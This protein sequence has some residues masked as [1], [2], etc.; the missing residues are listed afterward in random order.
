M[1]EIL[2]TNRETL[3][4][5]RPA[6]WPE[7]D[8]AAVTCRTSSARPTNQRPARGGADRRIRQTILDNITDIATATDMREGLKDPVLGAQDADAQ[9]VSLTGVSKFSKVSLFS[10]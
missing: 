9:V 3:G 1:Q 10:G 7:A 4:L 8:T 5:P 6:D 2:R